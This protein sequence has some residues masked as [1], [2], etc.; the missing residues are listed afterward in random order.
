M[1]VDTAAPQSTA[2]PDPSVQTDRAAVNFTPSTDASS[3]Q[4]YPDNPESPL[5]RYRFAAK[6]PSQ[7][8]DPCQE[9]ANMS[10]KCLE[11]NNYDRDLCREYF[12]AYRECKKQWLSARRKD[13]SQW[14]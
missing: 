6:G 9:S 8:F 1:P 10:M 11:R 12:D 7:Y 2:N 5:A 3:F 13:N 4:F 14:T